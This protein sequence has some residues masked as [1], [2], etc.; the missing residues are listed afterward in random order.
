MQLQAPTRGPVQ[1]WLTTVDQRNLLA[2]QADVAWQDADV[3]RPA[4]PDTRAITVDADTR[5][6]TMDGCGTS[7][8]ESSAFLLQTRLDAGQRARVM[9]SLF[10]P[11]GIRLS[12]VRQP[13]GACD[14]ARHLYTYADDKNAGV[15]G[16]SI[17]DDKSHILPTLR[18]AVSIYPSLKVIATPWSPPG[19]MKSS[20]SII[21]GTLLPQCYKD[22]GE[23]FAKFV[24]AYRG[25]G[26]KVWAV[27]PQNEP[28]YVPVH[29]PGMWLP[30]AD[31]A[32]FIKQGLGPALQAHGLD[33][34]ILA[35]DHNWDNAAYPLSVLADPEASKYVAGVAWHN[36]GGSPD[37]M[38][39]VHDAHPDKGAWFT[40]GSGG[41]WV[42][43]FHDAFMA[44][45]SNV[46]NV[47]RNWGQSIIWWNAALDSQHGPSLL[48]ARSTC[49]GLVTIDNC[50]GQVSYNVDYYTIGHLS[51]FVAPGAQRIASNTFD[52]DV[53]DVAFQNPDGSK[54]MV[55]SNR[56]TDEKK[57]QVRDGDR[58]FD[59][60][61]P[62]ES[63]ASFAWDIPSVAPMPG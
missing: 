44:Q 36:Y 57:V 24:E 59:V 32:A 48:G 27:T 42:P 33:T 15:S 22:Y 1:F 52:N 53:E 61:L 18:E 29:Y 5:Y 56:T 35:F 28:G 9:Q 45:M 20:G 46:V 47:P 21:G 54:V 11:D 38:S 26:V 3:T 7:I 16:F 34:K 2:R 39:A 40:E 17:D 49:R 14:Y 12:M 13:M 8:T 31:E 6:Q 43:A 19:W 60:T 51:K 23:Y 63:A 58:C 55:V 62:G 41:E 37:A 30:P 50:S 10:G 4:A 25:E